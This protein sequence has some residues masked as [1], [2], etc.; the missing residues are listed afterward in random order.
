MFYSC[1]PDGETESRADWRHNRILH[2][3]IGSHSGNL[4]LSLERLRLCSSFLWDELVY[5][6]NDSAY[7]QILSVRKRMILTSLEVQKNKNTHLSMQRQPRLVIDHK[8]FLNIKE[9][10]KQA[11]P[12]KWWAELMSQGATS[13]F[14]WVERVCAHLKDSKVICLSM[15]L[16]FYNVSS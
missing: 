3:W 5:S 10:E 15:F 12:K 11:R 2:D 8:Y 9:N 1:L 16:L 6:L 13:Q 7:I 14:S 4:T